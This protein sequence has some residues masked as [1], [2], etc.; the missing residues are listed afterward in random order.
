MPMATYASI[1][2]LL[3]V[4]AMEDE[5]KIAMDLCQDVKRMHGPSVSL[6][7]GTID[8]RLFYFQKVGVGPKKSAGNLQKALNQIVPDRILVI[9]YAGAL[10]P[11]LQLG[12][13]VAVTKASAFSLDKSCPDWN[14]VQLNG[15]YELAQAEPMVSA[16]KFAGLDAI[17]GSALSSSH[18]LGKPEHKSLL[19]NR[20]QASAVDME[21]AFLARLAASR[22][23]SMSCIRTISDIAQDSFLE[24]FSYDPA[25]KL[26]E[27]AKKL[28]NAG[29]AQTYREWKNHTSVAKLSLKGFLENYLKQAD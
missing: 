11:Q 5:L 26:A 17:A 28:F 22:N 18:V 27:R 8:K 2:M 15:I 24:P 20:F 4:A 3:I 23:I 21:T 29:M 1:P 13:L 6:W 25:A 16:A 9:G 19:H 14:H 7:Q 12:S 10:D